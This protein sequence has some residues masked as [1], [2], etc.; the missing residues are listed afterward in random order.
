[1]TKIK[2]DTIIPDTYSTTEAVKELGIGYATLFRWI[3]T[4]RIFTI[5]IGHRTLIPKSEIIRCIAHT[6][7]NCFHWQPQT[8][9]CACRERDN[10]INKVNRCPDWYPPD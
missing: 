9:T 2:V 4:N 10:T 7:L 6:C 5:K 3:K 1:M 8:F